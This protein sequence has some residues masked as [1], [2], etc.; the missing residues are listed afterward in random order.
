MQG[1]EVKDIESFCQLLSEGHS[2]AWWAQTLLCGP[3]EVDFSGNILEPKEPTN[4]RPFRFCLN[5]L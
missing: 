1:V 3:L 2:Q 4:L 5:S